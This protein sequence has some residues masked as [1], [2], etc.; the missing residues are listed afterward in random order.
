MLE[1]QDTI[2]EQLKDRAAKSRESIQ[3]LEVR[4]G[5]MI[6]MILIDKYITD[7]VD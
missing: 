6:M 4:N 3:K 2:L 1:D 5:I 7:K